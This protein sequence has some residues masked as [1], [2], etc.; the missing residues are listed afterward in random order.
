MILKLEKIP[1]NIMKRLET[2][3]K[4]LMK[5]G[6]HITKVVKTKDCWVVCVCDEGGR[7]L[8]QPPYAFRSANGK[9]FYYD[10]MD[11]RREKAFDKGEVL[12]EDTTMLDMRKMIDEAK[13]ARAAGGKKKQ[14][15]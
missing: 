9:L 2:L 14:D 4:D 11:E 13:R 12:I 10:M 7:L 1:D 3:M 6:Q 15:A 5:Q 8:T